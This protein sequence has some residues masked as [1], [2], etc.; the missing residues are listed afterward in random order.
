M[1]VIRFGSLV[2]PPLSPEQ[3]NGPCSEPIAWPVSF[4]FYHYHSIFVT[5][6]IGHYPPR[7][8]IITPE[9]IIITLEKLFITLETKFFTPQIHFS[10]VQMFVLENV[11]SFLSGDNTFSCCHDKK[12]S[13]H[14][15]KMSRKVSLIKPNIEDIS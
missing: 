8:I 9:K 13:C 4:A 3:R 2:I 5:L 11:M 10:R 6:Q 7:K 14:D 1:F 12:N 15:K